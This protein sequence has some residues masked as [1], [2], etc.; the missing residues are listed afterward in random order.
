MGT[1]FFKIQSENIEMPQ[2]FVVII[3][4]GDH[5]KETCR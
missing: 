4:D 2:A 5:L 3:L 1:R